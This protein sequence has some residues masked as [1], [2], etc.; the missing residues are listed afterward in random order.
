MP[1]DSLVK[2]YNDVKL[3]LPKAIA[4]ANA[5]LV[6]AMPVSQALEEVQPRA[7]GAVAGEV[8]AGFSP[9]DCQAG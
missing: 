3:A 8:G 9:P 5:M 2:Q 6:K 4:D 1:S 7:D